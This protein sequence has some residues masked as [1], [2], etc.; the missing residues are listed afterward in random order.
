LVYSLRD[1]TTGSGDVS[2]FQID[3]AT[4]VISL[5]PNQPLDYETKSNLAI[6]V[7]ATDPGGAMAEVSYSVT[8]TDVN[9]APAWS[10]A[11]AT[12]SVAENQASAG[13][14]TATDP[15]GGGLTYS[16]TGGADQSLFTIDPATGALSFITAPDFEAPTDIGGNN[17]YDVMMTASDGTNSIQRT[18]AITVTDVNEALSW[19]NAETTAAVA[20]NQANVG[21]FLANDPD[22]DALSFTL[23]GTDAALF[24]YNAVTGALSFKSNPTY[25]LGG[26]N[27]YELTLTVSDGEFDITKNLVIDVEPG[28]AYNSAMQK[29]YNYAQDVANP[30]PDFADFDILTTH[31]NL[32]LE[33]RYNT[34]ATLNAAGFTDPSTDF[35]RFLTEVQNYVA[36]QSQN[37]DSL[38]S[39]NV[40]TPANISDADTFYATS[41]AGMFENNQLFNRDISR[42]DT[43]KVTDM[44]SMFRAAAAF[45]QDIGFWDVSKVTDMSSMFRAAAAFNQDI[46]GWDVSKV[47]DMSYM[48][49][50][51]QFF[52]QD[53]GGWDVSKVTYMSYMFESAAAFNQDIGDW[54]VSKV[55][56]MSYMFVSAEAFNQDIGDWD[57]SSVTSANN[58]LGG[59]T[60][61]SLENYDKLLVGW[62]DVNTAL[63]ET[64]LQSGVA[65]GGAPVGYTNATAMIYMLETYNWGIRDGGYMG[66]AGTLGSNNSET[67]NHSAAT[68]SQTLHGIGGH[69]TLVGGAAADHLYGGAGNDRL[70]GNGGADTF[71]YLFTNAGNDTITDFN[72]TEDKIDIS[73]LLDGFGVGGYGT[74]LADFVTVTRNDVSKTV[75]LTIDAN[76]ANATAVPAVTIT[77][78]NLA[79]YTAYDTLQELMDANA[80]IYN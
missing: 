67:L 74:T 6:T 35:D 43:G 40:A 29:V 34:H 70:A 75:T 73:V 68:T 22:G 18:V 77:L 20:E 13:T 14:Y 4:G 49:S 44:S 80:L 51:T 31:A 39:G 21:T 3:S 27:R 47:T 72:P 28:A 41:M 64:G 8:V 78:E 25:N 10:N 60:S 53:I 42:W 30:Q 66:D 76:G 56:N 2:Y 12:A 45:N 24:N 69:D 65:F 57:V 50:G 71:H 7:V 61:F 19:D 33:T 32:M 17:V 11:Q 9:E 16:I 63:G 55:T 1:T 15:E 54:D 46:G 62:A 79:D 36:T 5:N 52:N 58:F 59:A 48:L 37:L 23:T 38:Y 26:D